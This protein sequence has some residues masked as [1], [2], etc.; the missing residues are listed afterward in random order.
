MCGRFTLKT[1]VLDWLCSLLPQFRDHW[2]RAALAMLEQAPKLCAPRYNI[3]PTQGIWVLVSGP[4]G[5]PPGVRAMRWGLVPSW[6]DA[7]SNSYS[8]INARCET[9]AEKPSFRNLLNHHRCIIVAD[10]YF[11]WQSPTDASNAKSP[12]TPYWIHRQGERPFAMAGLWTENRRID[13]IASITS[14]TIIT[15]ASNQDTR[16]VHDRMP[17]LL[18]RPDSIQRWLNLPLETETLDPFWMPAPAGSLQLRRVSARV[19]SPKND[20]DDLIEPVAPQPSF[21]PTEGMGP[22]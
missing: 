8:M 3:A 22:T 7:L 5:D 19:N 11:E 20:A 14:A 2:A 12:K 6:A 4:N 17:V 15:T 16:A 10:G 9:L 1:S 13:P 21:D 18:D